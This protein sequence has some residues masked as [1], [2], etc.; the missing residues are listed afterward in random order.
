ML[1][2][3]EAALE[4][5]RTDTGRQDLAR[6][7]GVEEGKLRKWVHMADLC[8][9]KGVGPDLAELLEASGVNTVKVLRTR[10]PKDLEA[11]MIEVNNMRKLTRTVPKAKNIQGWVTAAGELPPMIES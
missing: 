7:T 1:L 8:R 9:I 3:A 5:G 6:R 4:A 2:S 10:N 11:R